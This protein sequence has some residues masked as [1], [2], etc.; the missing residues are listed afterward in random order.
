MALKAEP[1]GRLREWLPVGRP[2]GAE[3]WN[4]RHRGVVVLLWVHAFGLGAFGLVRGFEPLHVAGEAIGIGGLAFVASVLQ[5]RTAQAAIGTLGL[6][7]SSAVLVHL[8]GG[9]IEAH[10]HFFI[11]VA[12]VT[13]YQSWIPFLVAMGYV[14]VHH[15][16]IGVIAPNSV[17][18]HPAAVRSPW[19][20]AAIHAAMVTGAALAG[21]MSWKQ[22]EIERTAAEIAAAELRESE[23]RKLGAVHLQDT[24]VQGLITA[25]YASE[26][27]EAETAAEAIDRTLLLAQNLVAELMLGDEALREPGGLRPPEPSETVPPP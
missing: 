15:G 3:V 1:I 20:W 8:S 22:A 9:M 11:M 7:T 4:S 6:I 19:L 12:V 5:T 18:N 14:L 24:V 13:S 27:G 21:L 10:F 17:Y 2:M 16:T 25:K 23:L 26:L